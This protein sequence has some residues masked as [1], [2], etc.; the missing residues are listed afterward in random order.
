MRRYE[1]T[2]PGFT[3]ELIGGIVHV[4]SRLAALTGEVRPT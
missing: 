4:A 2:P 1:L 3:A